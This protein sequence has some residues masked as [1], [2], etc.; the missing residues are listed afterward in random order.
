MRAGNVR[1]ANRRV[2]GRASLYASRHDSGRAFRPAAN[3]LLE[4]VRQ[5][6]ALRERVSTQSDTHGLVM[7]AVRA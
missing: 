5:L 7:F 2:R 6:R 1:T 3:R 4:P